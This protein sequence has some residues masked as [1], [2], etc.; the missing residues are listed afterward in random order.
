MLSRRLGVQ[1][2]DLKVRH[3]GLPPRPARCS[4]AGPPA[5]DWRHVRLEWPAA[6]GRRGDVAGLRSAHRGSISEPL[7]RWT[8]Y[9]DLLS[10][11]GAAPRIPVKFT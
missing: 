1:T 8:F 5:I 4:K 6:L 2:Q 3:L 7:T 11:R 10:R 9:K